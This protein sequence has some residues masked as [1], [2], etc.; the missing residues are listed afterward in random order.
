M[1]PGRNCWLAFFR[2][3]VWT[4]L[5]NFSIETLLQEARA[6]PAGQSCILAKGEMTVM[7]FPSRAVEEPFACSIGI[8]LWQEYRKRNPDGLTI[9][10][11][12]GRNV[13]D[14]ELLSYVAH[15]DTFNDCNEV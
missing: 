4:G 6:N 11:T 7:Q 5:P 8:A 3:S 15:V 12:D 13:K 9:P 1:D 14:P 10:P 2:L